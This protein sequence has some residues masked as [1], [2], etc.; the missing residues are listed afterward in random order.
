MSK[1]TPQLGVSSTQQATGESAPTVL[2]L[3]DFDEYERVQKRSG[4]EVAELLIT[5]DL[6]A[7]QGKDTLQAVHCAGAPA[8]QPGEDPVLVAPGSGAVAGDG[9]EARDGESGLEDT[10]LPMPETGHD[11]VGGHRCRQG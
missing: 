2:S 8:E 1:K 9:G 4:K 7:E 3:M 11:P 5:H 6:V 10:T